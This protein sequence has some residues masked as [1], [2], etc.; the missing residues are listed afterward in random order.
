MVP[1]NDT[2]KQ[3]LLLCFPVSYI[4]SCF[5]LQS[6]LWLLPIQTLYSS[7]IEP[8]GVLQIT[9]LPFYLHFFSLSFSLPPFPLLSCHLSLYLCT[10]C[11]VSVSFLWPIG[12]ISLT[13]ATRSLTVSWT[14]KAHSS[15]EGLFTWCSLCLSCPSLKFTYGCFHFLHDSVQISTQFYL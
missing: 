11:K 2:I 7:K 10:C 12:I 5:P 6:H 4:Q 1:H 3:E 13:S 9:K 15:P 8:P 14:H